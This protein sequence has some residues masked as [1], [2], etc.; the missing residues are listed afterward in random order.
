LRSRGANTDSKR[1]IRRLIAATFCAVTAVANATAFEGRLEVSITRGSE[2]TPLLYTLGTDSL[3]LEV[4]R[5]SS[6]NPIDIVDLKTGALTLVFPHNRSFVRLE[7]GAENT[8]AVPAGAPG[9]PIPSGG[10]PSG[11]GPQATSDNVLQTPS[12]PAGMRS[13]PA[14]AGSLPTG[15]GPQHGTATAPDTLGMPKMPAMPPMP[16]MTEKLEFKATGKKEKILGYACEQYEL[17][18]RGET[19]EIWATDQ[20]FPY[21]PYVRSQ[22]HRFGPRMLEEQWPQML[23]SR[24]LFPLRVSLRFDNGPSRTGGAER[25]HFEV[26]SI[27]PEKITDD[28]M[29]LF[30]PPADY[31][32]ARPLPF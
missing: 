24:K 11:V 31:N 16:A 29:K 3:R 30:Q 13:M 12:L 15:I 9:M 28:D 6:P 8:S 5:T 26:K 23:T 17:K 7:P 10:L 25:F 14:P 19:L 27:T 4:T 1:S 18:Q 22:P 21:Q 20:L 2:T 32:E